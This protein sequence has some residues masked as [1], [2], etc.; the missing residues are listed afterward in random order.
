MIL[1]SWGR[2]RSFKT[3]NQL[4]LEG[5]KDNLTIGNLRSYGDQAYNHNVNLTF[6]NNRILSFNKTKV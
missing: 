3:N 2:L 6:Q 4:I 5:K 1:S